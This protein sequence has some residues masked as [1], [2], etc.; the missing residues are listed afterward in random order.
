MDY[1]IDACQLVRKEVFDMVGLV[2]E[3]IFYG[4]ED[5]DFCLSANRKGWNIINL[6]QVS[7]IHNTNK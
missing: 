3:K 2:D 1:V 4:P 6:P 7:F 5:N